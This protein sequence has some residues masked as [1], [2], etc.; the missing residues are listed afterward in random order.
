LV[1]LTNSLTTVL[2]VLRLLD[3][4]PRR[5]VLEAAI[6]LFDVSLPASEATL[7]AATMLT[8]GRR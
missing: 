6:I 5:R 8:K 2:G 4:E 7:Q 3:P 1:D